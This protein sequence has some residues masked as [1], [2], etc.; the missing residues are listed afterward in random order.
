MYMA[1]QFDVRASAGSENAVICD[2]EHRF[3]IKPVHEAMVT[4]DG[5]M[6]LPRGQGWSNAA[7]WHWERI[8]DRERSL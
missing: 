3:Q 5:Y 8:S 7:L 4:A 2:A 6:W 1:G